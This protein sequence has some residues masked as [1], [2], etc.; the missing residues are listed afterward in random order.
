MQIR[1]Q[2]LAVDPRGH[3][4]H[5][6]MIAPVDPEVDVAHHVPQQL[7]DEL[8]QVVLDLRPRPDVLRRAQL[9]HHDRDE[10]RDHAVAERFEP[11]RVHRGLSGRASF[12][13]E[14]S[15]TARSIWVRIARWLRTRPWKSRRSSTS[16]WQ[17][18]SAMTSA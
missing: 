18:E 3:V 7:G 12:I 10:D 9:E 1:P 4:E 17:Y 13:R 2:D 11:G 5:V 8:G 15:A 14:R 6:V 16:S